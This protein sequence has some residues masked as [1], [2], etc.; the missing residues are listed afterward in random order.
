M[1]TRKRAIFGIALG[2]AVAL[3]TAAALP[4]AASGQGSGADD[5]VRAAVPAG[6][7]NNVVVIDLEN[8]S[9][10]STFGPSSPA[11]YLNSVLVPSGELIENYYATS[12]VSLGN[13][14]SQISGQA[15]TPSQNNDCI[16][17][18]SF[19]HPPVTGSFTNVTPGTPAANGQVHGDGCVF[20][21]AVNTIGSQ[22]DAQYG[23][24]KQVVFPWRAYAEDMG[25]DPVR[26]YGTPD[27]LGGTDCAHAPIGGVDN[28]NSAAANDQYATRHNGFVYFHSTIDDAAK[29]DERVVPLGTVTVGPDGHDTFSGH[30]AQD[31]SKKQTTP[32]FSFIT[33]NLCNDGHDATC[34][35]TNVEGGKAG[36]LVGADLW[37]KHWMPFIM[38]SPSYKS[39]EMLIV[40]TFDEA[41]ISDASACCGEQPGP[42]LSNPG[43]SPLL[44]LFGLQ[45][46]PTGPGQYPGGGKVGAVLLNKKYIAAGTDNTT[47]Q[48]NH[49]SALRSYE[50]IL[51]IVSGGDDGNG[52]LGF[53][54]ADGLAPFGSDVFNRH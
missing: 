17:F 37:L 5:V 18:A 27:P 13:Y 29:C 32:L 41:G 52:H 44:G 21:A 23:Q 9:F 15:S 28:S 43:F 26:D 53:A 46:P 10:D 24:D 20:P 2:A 12:H 1:R 3:A 33:P 54:G 36:G 45:T 48:Y 49:Y 11:H 25:N 8:E 14:A 16:N 7:I 6:K 30:L 50:D 34:A 35:G 47:G 51:G 31:F 38:S 40:I 4:A 42:N 39:G 19:A 22:L